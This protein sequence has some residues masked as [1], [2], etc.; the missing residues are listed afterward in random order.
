MLLAGRALLEEHA[1]AFI[2]ALLANLGFKEDP[3]VRLEALRGLGVA[4]KLQYNVI[5]PQ[6]RAVLKAL[7]QAVDDPKRSLRAEAAKICSLWLPA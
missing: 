2:Q 5:H 6:R 1:D 7:R 3:D 4:A